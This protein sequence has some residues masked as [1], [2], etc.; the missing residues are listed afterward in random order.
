MIRSFWLS[1]QKCFILWLVYGYILI[2][3][4]PVD[5]KAQLNNFGFGFTF[6]YLSLFIYEC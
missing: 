6:A 2:N 4:W 1:Y 3:K 5:Y